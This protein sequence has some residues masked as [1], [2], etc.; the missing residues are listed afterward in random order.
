MSQCRADGY[1]RPLSGINIRHQVVRRL[2]QH[3][4][5]ARDGNRL[6]LVGKQPADFPASGNLCIVSTCNVYTVKANDT[7]DSIARASNITVPQ[8][9]TWNPVSAHATTMTIRS[10]G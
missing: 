5:L 2:L 4:A 10:S 3:F 8:L 6:A 1:V 7:C 9:K